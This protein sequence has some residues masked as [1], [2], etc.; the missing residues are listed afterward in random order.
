[1]DKALSEHRSGRAA[2]IILLVSVRS[3]T[4][5]WRSLRARGYPN[6]EIHKRVKFINPTRPGDGP[7]FASTLF[8]L[9]PNVE[10]FIE[11]FGVKGEPVGRI[12]GEAA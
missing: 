4:R 10:R 6:I 1:V 3:D 11:V 8:Y 2:Q 5:W 9:G 12:G 7:S